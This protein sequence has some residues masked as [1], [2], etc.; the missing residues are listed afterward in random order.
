M[1]FSESHISDLPSEMMRNI[2]SYL[3]GRSLLN[4]RIVSKSWNSEIDDKL[5]KWHQFCQSEMRRSIYVDLLIK[6]DPNGRGLSDADWRNIYLMWLNPKD[7]VKDVAFVKVLPNPSWNPITNKIQGVTTHDNLILV[8]LFVKV[9]EEVRDE[10]HVWILHGH[11]VAGDS[12]VFTRRFRI[13]PPVEEVHPFPNLQKLKLIR[14]ARYNIPMGC[15]D[16]KYEKNA[17][18]YLQREVSRRV[19]SNC[20][21]HRIF[22]KYNCTPTYYRQHGSFVIV[23]TNIGTLFCF[24]ETAKGTENKLLIVIPTDVVDIISIDVAWSATHFFI[25]FANSDKLG[26]VAILRNKGNEVCDNDTDRSTGCG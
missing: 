26:T 5:L 2:F 3:D 15:C 14:A 12:P 11:L 10:V 19:L 18:E 9:A 21:E 17:S 20:V 7:I 8:Q 4:C 24:H 22:N 25:V 6:H 1:T 16:K 23:G 13:N